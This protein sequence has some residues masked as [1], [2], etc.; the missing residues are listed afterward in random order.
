M[1]RIIYSLFFCTLFLQLS[2]KGQEDTK[3]NGVSF[4]A[5]PDVAKQE[6]VDPVIKINANSAAIM[7]F[8][9]IRDLTNPEVRYNSD[10][11]WFGETKKGAKQYI[12]LLHKNNIQVML[13]P[14]IWVWRGEFTGNIK[15]NSEEDWKALESSYSKFILDYADLAQTT[16]VAL[17]CIGTEL[18]QF[19][20]LRP[21]YWKQ[22]IKEIR[23][24]YKGKLT[25]AANWDEYPKTSFWQDLDYIG[26]DAY[27]PI[28]E[29]KTPSLENLK[30]GWVKHKTAIKGISDKYQKQ[31]LFTEFGYRSVD[32]TGSKPWEVDYSKTSVNLQG[33]VN[34]TQVIFDT[35]WHEEWFAGGYIWKWFI[36]YD[37]AGG[38]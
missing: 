19:V 16:Q 30:K 18:E 17:F 4:V 33:Q 14:Q 20:K 1:K 23:N 15:M 37:R 11:Q 6:H 21:D 8:G 28:C 24:I 22:L 27:F 10:R 5:S 12:E 13:K 31:I 25:Y 9:F 7:P 35:F 3:I 38:E 29:E 36:H 2:C 32:F 26:I 34:A